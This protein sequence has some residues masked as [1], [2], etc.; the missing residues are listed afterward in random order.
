MCRRPAL[1]SVGMDATELL[2]TLCTTI[3]ERRWEDLRPLLS[4]G[5][6][7]RYVHTGEVLDADTWVRTNAEYPDFHRMVLEDLVGHG[8][9]AVSRCHVTGRSGGESVAFE[10]ASFVTAAAGQITELTE[11]WTDVGLTPPEGTRPV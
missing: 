7:C 2:R 8:G 11:V 6:A 4:D 9:R 10:V 3:D 1:V 5:F